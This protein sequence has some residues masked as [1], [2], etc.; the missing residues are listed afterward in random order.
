VRGRGTIHLTLRLRIA[1]DGGPFA[2]W[3]AQPGLRTVE[4]ELVAALERILGDSVALTAAGRTD[5]GVHAWGQV[6]SLVPP[7]E[8]PDTLLR[9]LNALLPGEIAVLG[10]DRA[11]DGFDARRDARSRTYCYRVLA[12]RVRSPF[13]RGRALHWPQRIDRAALD[14]CAAAL[15]GTHDFTAFTPTDTEHVRFE[16]DILRAEWVWVEAVPPLTRPSRTRERASKMTSH[17]SA[18]ERERSRR[19]EGD[20]E[21]S[22]GMFWIEADAFM[23]HMVR[24]LVGT[25][26]EVAGGRRSLEEFERLLEGAP[27]ERAG[28]T[29]APHGLYLASV[30]YE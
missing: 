25:M 9:G 21:E 20:S 14:E 2:G 10:A 5:A 13:E 11:A 23:R 16:R 28:E 24:V 7:G 30:R 22:I 27:R 3:A 1:Y 18:S 29:A 15:A 19:P 26:L 6:A 17:V 12:S 4:G 8:P